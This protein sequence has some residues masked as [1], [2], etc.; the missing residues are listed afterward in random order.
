[1]GFTRSGAETR[2]VLLVG[3]CAALMCWTRNGALLFPHEIAAWGF[4]RPAANELELLLPA[5][6]ALLGQVASPLATRLGERVP[7]KRAALLAAGGSALSVAAG[8]VVGGI[9]GLLLVTL[10]ATLFGIAGNDLG[11]TA[12]L[13]AVERS[14]HER[15]GGDEPRVRE[16]RTGAAKQRANA[17]MMLALG[18]AQ[19]APAWASVWIFRT[20]DTTTY[21]LVLAAV[22]TVNWAFFWVVCPRPARDVERPSSPVNR[23]EL[24]LAA[25]ISFA[26]VW[27]LTSW[28]GFIRPAA[29]DL[30]VGRDGAAASQVSILIGGFVTF[31]LLLVRKRDGSPLFKEDR[32]LVTGAVTTAVSFVTAFG[33]LRGA[34][35]TA[36]RALALTVGRTFVEM[37]TSITTATILLVFATS[38][39]AQASITRARGAA[40]L[41]AIV[42]GTVAWAV[43][44]PLLRIVWVAA[45]GQLFGLVQIGAVLA[46]YLLRRSLRRRAN[47]L[48]ETERVPGLGRI[49]VWRGRWAQPDAV[50][51]PGLLVAGTVARRPEPPFTRAERKRQRRFKDEDRVDHDVEKLRHQVAVTL[52]QHAQ[53]KKVGAVEVWRQRNGGYAVFARVGMSGPAVVALAQFEASRIRKAYGLEAVYLA[54]LGTGDAGPVTA[55]DTRVGLDATADKRVMHVGTRDDGTLVFVFET[56]DPDRRQW[57]RSLRKAYEL[58]YAVA[59]VGVHVDVLTTVAQKLRETADAGAVWREPVDLHELAE[60]IAE[61]ATKSRLAEGPCS[62]WLFWATEGLIAHI[63]IQPRSVDAADHLAQW[64]AGRTFERFPRLAGVLVG[65][66]V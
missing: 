36:E 43:F 11:L 50:I 61:F 47:S 56:R 59:D 5:I 52:G 1:V 29:E 64:V 44:E 14:A 41:A 35:T 42:L 16:K 12:A 58:Q 17:W 49:A 6:L 38:V 51:E 63:A 21:F 22:L 48:R 7:V 23:W 57:S 55:A 30:G 31:A 28:D 33:L 65:A 9:P 3:F 46:W 60:Q 8:A 4:G 37:G 19:S 24:R 45:P 2:S 18:V 13:R 66:A 62:V 54:P 25:F 34:E 53:I 15:H 32:L 26:S 40:Q 20:S 10:V 39:T 27:Q